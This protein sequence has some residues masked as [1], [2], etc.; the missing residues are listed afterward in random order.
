MKTWNDARLHI[1]GLFPKFT[2]TEEERGLITKTLSPLD[3]DRV[4]EAADIYR[5]EE[6]GVVF[7]LSSFLTIYKKRNPIPTVPNM[8]TEAIV[9]EREEALEREKEGALMAIQNADSTRLVEAV[10]KLNS[11]KWLKEPLSVE[12]IDLWS[13]SAIFKITAILKMEDEL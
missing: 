1:R 9:L 13:R 3:A 11:R 7:R 10:E 6:I 2:P 5:C 4:I 12:N 8:H